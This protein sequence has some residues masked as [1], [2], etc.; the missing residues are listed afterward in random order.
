MSKF[1]IEGQWLFLK[2][3]CKS[4]L[5]FPY[6]QAIFLKVLVKRAISTLFTRRNRCNLAIFQRKNK[7]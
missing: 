2:F 5:H 3:F 4:S 6:L 1:Y 7:K